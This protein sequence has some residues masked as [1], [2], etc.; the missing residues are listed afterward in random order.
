LIF[1]AFWHRFRHHFGSLLQLF[2]CFFDICFC[3][4]FLSTF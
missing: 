2:S 1:D 4:D 3:I